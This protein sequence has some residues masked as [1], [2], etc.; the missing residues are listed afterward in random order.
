M[1]VKAEIEIPYMKEGGSLM[2]LIIKENYT[3]IEKIEDLSNS[4]LKRM[5]IYFK[6][7]YQLSVINSE[8]YSFGSDEGLFEIAPMRHNEVDCPELF[9]EKDQGGYVLGCCDKEKVIYYVNKIGNLE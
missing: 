4:F 8:R 7:G 5:R 6:N 2:D 1:K 9:D 3:F